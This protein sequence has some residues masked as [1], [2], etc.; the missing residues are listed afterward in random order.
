MNFVPPDTCLQD[1]KKRRSALLKHL[2]AST[3]NVSGRLKSSGDGSM[4][5]HFIA[6]MTKPKI[7]NPRA[8]LTQTGRPNSW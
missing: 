7:Q 1:Y 4:K 5:T 3:P 2:I 6:T 8:R